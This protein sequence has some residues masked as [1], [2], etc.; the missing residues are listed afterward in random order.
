[1]KDDSQVWINVI[2]DGQPVCADETIADPFH[3][4]QLTIHLARGDLLRRL[5]G[6]KP[7]EIA[8]NV[9]VS[10]NP[11]ALRRWFNGPVSNVIEGESWTPAGPAAGK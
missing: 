11:A 1:M 2:V 5:L 4:T 10:G 6:L 7:R 9:L 3:N 8:I